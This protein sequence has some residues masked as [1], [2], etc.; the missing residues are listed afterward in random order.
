QDN[1]NIGLL[2]GPVSGGLVDIDLDC[3]EAF[4]AAKVLLPR[5][6]AI[7]GREG[8]RSSHYLY[9]SNDVVPYRKFNAP[10]G[11]TV[12][13]VRSC[14]DNPSHYT[15]VPPSFRADLGVHVEWEGEGP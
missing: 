1:S 8:A 9:Q 14:A 4:E 12:L 11:A 7:F 3:P 10:G 5:T 13:E 2:L 15:L 6:D